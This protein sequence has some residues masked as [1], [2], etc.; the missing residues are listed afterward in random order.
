MWCHN[1]GLHDFHVIVKRV[2]KAA[3]AQARD[4]ADEGDYRVT[5]AEGGPDIEMQSLQPPTTTA[6]SGASR[7]PVPGKGF[8]PVEPSNMTGSHVRSIDEARGME[9]GGF[10]IKDAKAKRG[11]GER[12]E[13]SE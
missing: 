6:K 12:G 13:E 1:V 5:E 8:G 2:E 7:L 9:G 3:G 4:E 11:G 10:G